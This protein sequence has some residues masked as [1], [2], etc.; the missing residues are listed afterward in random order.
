[1]F[2]GKLFFFAYCVFF[3]DFNFW[4]GVSNDKIGL[5]W[6]GLDFGDGQRGR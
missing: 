3:L 6:I 5:D 1:M 4:G 2:P